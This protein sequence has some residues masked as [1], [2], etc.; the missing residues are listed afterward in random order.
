VV[1]IGLSMIGVS[2]GWGNVN[3]GCVIVLG[4]LGMGDDN[5]RLVLWGSMMVAKKSLL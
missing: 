4:G 1:Y 5:Q 3:D 2:T